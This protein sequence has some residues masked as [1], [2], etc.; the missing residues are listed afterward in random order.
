[1]DTSLLP[2]PQFS[3]EFKVCLEDDP[4]KWIPGRTG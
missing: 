4:D 3:C 1:M 2:S